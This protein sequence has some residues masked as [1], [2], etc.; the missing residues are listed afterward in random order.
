[1]AAH[2]AAY[3]SRD[4]GD[5]PRVLPGARPPSRMPPSDTFSPVSFI[6]DDGSEIEATF[7]SGCAENQRL[8]LLQAMSRSGARCVGDGIEFWNKGNDAVV[9]WQGQ[10]FSCSTAK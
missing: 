4:S 6:C 2:Q 3:K 9:D 7:G 10:K 5:H 8:R 1:M